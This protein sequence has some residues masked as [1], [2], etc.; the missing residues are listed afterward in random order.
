[1]TEL[2]GKSAT[3]MLTKLLKSKT[4]PKPT[5]DGNAWNSGA[6]LDPMKPLAGYTC[7]DFCNVL[8]GPA[9]GRMMAE[10]GATG[11]E[12]TLTLILTLGGVLV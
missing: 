5:K 8:A 10:L 4:T 11:R 6:V 12:L 7:V 3:A 2:E 1:M 9:C